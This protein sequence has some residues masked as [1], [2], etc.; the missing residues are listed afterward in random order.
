[1]ES[2]LGAFVSMSFNVKKKSLG[3]DLHRLNGRRKLLEDVKAMKYGEYSV[4]NA[5]N[6][7]VCERSFAW[8][9]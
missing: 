7:E 1:M 6:N 2:F 3:E 8:K 4:E 9:R 5:V